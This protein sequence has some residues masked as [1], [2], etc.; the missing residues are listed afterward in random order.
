MRHINQDTKNN[1]RF[2]YETL[3]REQWASVQRLTREI[4]EDICK[5]AH[6]IWSIGKKLVEVR[7][8]LE[9]CQFSLWLRIEFD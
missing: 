9:T 2:E 8:Q 3:S 4:K 7:S 6:V 5:T 1:A